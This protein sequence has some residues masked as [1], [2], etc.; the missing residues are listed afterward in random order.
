[1]NALL[2]SDCPKMVNRMN[3]L[4]RVIFFNLFFS[5]INLQNTF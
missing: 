1:M 4:N 3:R 2:G 5:S